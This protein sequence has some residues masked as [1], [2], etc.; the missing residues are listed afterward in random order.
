MFSGLEDID[1]STY[2]TE[3][4]AVSDLPQHLQTRRRHVRQQRTA[5]RM[6]RVFSWAFWAGVVLLVVAWFLR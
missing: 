1:Y 6:T 5:Q 4:E 2:S 3:A